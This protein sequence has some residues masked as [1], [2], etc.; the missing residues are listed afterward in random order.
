MRLLGRINVGEV[1]QGRV[2]GETM[3]NALVVSL[4]ALLWEREAHGR[5]DLCF[6]NSLRFCQHTSLLGCCSIV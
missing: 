4:H 5:V 3:G 2:V 1:R 6:S